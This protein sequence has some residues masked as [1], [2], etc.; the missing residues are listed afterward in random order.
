MAH[1]F[2]TN[3]AYGYEQLDLAT[4]QS[5]HTPRALFAPAWACP[6]GAMF[7]PLHSHLRRVRPLVWLAARRTLGGKP[8]KTMWRRARP[9]VVVKHRSTDAGSAGACQGRQKGHYC[10]M[11]THD[12]IT[13]R[14]PFFRSGSSS[15]ALTPR[16]AVRMPQIATL[17]EQLTRKA[18]KTR[19]PPSLSRSVKQIGQLTRTYNRTTMHSVP[20][21]AARGGRGGD[22]ME[23]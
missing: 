2:G 4:D 23:S 22:G 18:I 1:F 19:T 15:L 12:N 8:N 5:F 9:A 11:I 6:G 20:S 14:G 17:F 10:F 7:D 13:R 3:T 21:P 16:A